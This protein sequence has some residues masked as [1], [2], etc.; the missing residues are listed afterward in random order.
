M[1]QRRPR[2][3][4]GRGSILGTWH[5]RLDSLG[6]AALNERERRVVEGV[7]ARL[8]EELQVGLLAVW[9]YGLPGS[10]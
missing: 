3:P 5:P 8:G 2:H 7:L 10:R 1:A 4:G 9:L 6:A